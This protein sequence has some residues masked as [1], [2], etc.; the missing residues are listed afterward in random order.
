VLVCIPTYNERENLPLIVRRIR[1]AVPSADVVVLDDNS[2]DGTG[3]VAD[4]LAE[5]DDQVHVLHRPGKQGLGMA[6]LAGFRW[7]LERGY[8]V[9]VEMDA[10]GSHQPEQL[11]LLLEAL[12][13]ADVVIGSR[14]VRGGSVVNWPLH[15]KALSVGGN[16]YTRALLGM[17]VADAT[18]GFRA[19]RAA[20]LRTIG[21]EA[22][23]SQGYCFQVDLTQRAVR[24]GLRV[25]E[26]PIT[27]VE[28][29]IGDSKMSGD[30][31]RES[32]QRITLWGL[33]HRAGQLRKVGGRISEREPTWHRL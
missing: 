4:G 16:L 26:V 24:A 31:M 27:F 2:P 3:E 30:I 17:R 10:D 32:L 19:Y 15:R 8:D 28:R 22:V 25:V 18:A 33:Q 29:E 23:A 21:L 1:A 14:W 20:A 6:Y 9:L 7:G 11:H 13:H 5:R 12:E